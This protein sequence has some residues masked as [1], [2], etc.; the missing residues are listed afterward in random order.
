MAE[1]FVIE[2]GHRLNGSVKVGG[3][4][5]A[6]LKLMAACLLTDKPVT[7][8]NVP[9]ILDVQYMSDILRKLG[10]TVE[11]P[12]AGALTIH[13]ENIKT[14]V[15]DAGL[16]QKMR[17][18]LVL[19]G[20]LLG[21]MGAVEL[22][23]PGGDKIGT[24]RVDS[25]VL[26]LQKLGASIDYTSTFK[27][28]ADGLKGADIFL[29]EASV[30]ATE[31]AIMAAAMAKGRSVIRN[32]ASEPHV[33]DLCNFLN[34]LGAHIEGIGTNQVTIE[35]VDKLG[36]GE[37][38]IGADYIETGS[39][40][41]AA[42][43][44][45]GEI[46]IQ[47]A[48]PQH[49]D[50]I[51]YA[52]RKVG[53]HCEIEGEDVIV[54]RHQ[55][56]KIEADLGNRVPTIKAQP[57]PAFPTDLMS[58]LLLVA[59]QCAGAVL[60]HEWMYDARLYFTDRLVAMGARIVLCDPH[61]ALVQGP[62]ALHSNLTISSPDIRAGITILLAALCAKGTTTIR[63]INHIDRGYERIEE[64]LASLGAKIQRVPVEMGA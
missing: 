41:G 44:T 38:R 5:N 57:W 39:F 15:V 30:T 1:Q 54:P 21:R 60:I 14:H 17:A 48:D 34:T 52:F 42:A 26:A 62:A 28:N 24:R 4:K 16:A 45:G 47:Q 29:D 6:V 10:A 59:T 51:L 7:L 3:N 63:N 37:F 9:D 8:R 61:R 40:I 36:G 19:A 53:V 22:A 35:G 49:L 58:V 18:S 25:H 11:R 64:K 31:N 50:M 20:A 27:M 23:L 13:A 33:Q 2:G 12:A 46:R 56:L 32:A 43:V 55:S